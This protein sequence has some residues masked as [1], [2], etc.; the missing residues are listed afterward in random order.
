MGT[1]GSLARPEMESGCDR[2]EFLSASKLAAVA[3]VC[4]NGWDNRGDCDKGA[5]GP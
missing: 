5:T 3:S 4:G 1:L 2:M